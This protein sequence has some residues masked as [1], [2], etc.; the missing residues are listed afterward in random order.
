M[1]LSSL[2]FILRPAVL[3][4]RL[5]TGLL[6]AMATAAP[7]TMASA[8]T[9]AEAAASI[10]AIQDQVAAAVRAHAAGHPGTL[11]LDIDSHG[12]ER[13]A[14]CESPHASL[15]PTQRLRS[16][17]SVAVRCDTPQRW[18]TYVQVRVDLHGPYLVAARA[19]EQGLALGPDTIDQREGDLLA[20]P[21]GTLHDRDLALG[22]ITTRRIG[23]GQVLR[24]NALRSPDA[25]QRGQIVRLIVRGSGFVASSE[26]EA[27]G[28]AD[29]GSPLQVRTASGQI[30]GGIVMPGGVV[31]VPL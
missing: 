29:P 16:R 27:L 4:A 6:L 23:A 14:P 1:R 26:G 21:R 9:D 10:Q 15:P 17:L 11:A 5:R 8:V 2:P 25:I 7:A 18:Q 30:V 3:L 22:Q 19:L 24:D 31:E 20:L 28:S 13:F 12:L